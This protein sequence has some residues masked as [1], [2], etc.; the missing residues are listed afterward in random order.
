M[1]TFD[2]YEKVEASPCRKKPIIIHATQVDEPFRVNSLEGDYKLGKAG[3]YLMCG[4][5]GEHYIC[6]KEIFEETIS[7][8]TGQRL[9]V[10]SSNLKIC[11]L[12]M[13][14]L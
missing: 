10:S 2:T 7:M 12:L 1:K 4:V 8:H 14:F 13:V 3:D 6:D 11:L 5:R 9:F